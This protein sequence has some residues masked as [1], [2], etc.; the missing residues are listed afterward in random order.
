MT[1][2]L[3]P[4]PL[5]KPSRQLLSQS[6]LKQYID[7]LFVKKGLYFRNYDD[8]WDWSVTDLEHF[9]ESISQFFDVQFTTPH[10]Y[11]LQPAD[12]GGVIGASWFGGATLN[13]AE[14]V[15]RQQTGARP[16][17]VFGA[18][19]RV[20]RE[21]SWA[22][23]A[24]QVA[25]VAAFLRLQ[26]VG[27]GDRVVAVLPNCP[28]AIVAF[29]ATNAV[30]AIWSVCSPDFGTA[31]IAGR[32]QL[33]G[34]K[35]LIGLDGYRYN[36][37]AVDKTEAIRDLQMALPTLTTTIR[38]PYP[39]YTDPLANRADAHRFTGSKSAG[40]YAADAIL[41]DDVLETNAPDGLIFEPVP[42]DH[43]IWVLYSSGFAGQPL[44]IAHS[45]GGCLLEHIKMLALHQDVRP[46]ERYFWYSSPGWMMWNVALSSLLVGATLV[47][48]D[49]AP[50]YPALT[51]LWELVE[52]AQVNHFGGG[53]AYFLTCMRSGINPIEAQRLSALRTIAMT[54]SP[55]PV[56]AFQ[57][58]YQSVKADVWLIS[59]SGGTDVCSGL[60]GGNPLLPVHAGEIQCR[61]LGCKVD[62]FDENGRPVGVQP[63]EMVVL[64]P[65]PSMPVYFWNDPDN[66]RYR[67]RY[68]EQTPVWW[69]GDWI[70]ITARNTVIMY[71]RSEAALNQDGVR[72]GTAEIYNVVEQLPEVTDSLVVGVERP[73]GSYF[74]PLFVVLRHGAT[75]DD[76]LKDAIRQTLRSRYGLRYT[77]DEIIQVDQI[78]Y[79]FS[80]K[81]LEIPVRKLLSGTD[82][83]L[84]VS[85]ETLRNPAALDA[86]V[87]LAGEITAR[88]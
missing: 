67:S 59:L 23:L 60:V 2:P 6:R 81:K 18:E 36:G 63:G 24:Q 29:L 52:V 42:F 66:T 19:Q 83:S 84:V 64:K 51:R 3:T 13:Y 4:V 75:L 65:M 88:W 28:E 32:F 61:L 43:P 79:T 1:T 30:G 37:R 27:V 50:A 73:G 31:S 86:F 70:K 39:G 78:P 55:V 44:A 45:T 46:G 58:I 33:I 53:T 20:L 15:F 87:Q 80:G 69:Y 56:E 12:D 47:L 48:Y 71:G 25:A 74:M 26:G 16:A 9:W 49:G 77:P 68:V 57:W 22:E 54:G 5:W 41:W 11:V 62:T 10:R 72:T 8:L 38:L 14:H 34:P 85:R 35:V 17:L 82:V 40:S 7:W 21:V 76:G